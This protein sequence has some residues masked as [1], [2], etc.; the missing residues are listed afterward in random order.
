MNRQKIAGIELYIQDVS[1]TYYN[2]WMFVIFL[3]SY[4]ILNANSCMTRA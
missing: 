4:F 3:N 1:V 2:V